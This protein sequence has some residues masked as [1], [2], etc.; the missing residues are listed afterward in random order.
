MVGSKDF[1]EQFV[2]GEM[3]VASFEAAGASVQNR[4]NLGGT[5]VNRQALEV[6]EIDVYAEYN[7]TGW[8]EHLGNVDPSDDPETLTQSVREQDLEENS[9]HWLSRSPFNNT[10][11]FATGPALTEEHGGEFDIQEMATYLQENPGA[12]VCMES[13]FPDR[14]DGLVLYQEATGHTIPQ[15]QINIIDTDLIYTE[16]AQGNCAFGE[17]FTTDGRIP[18]LGL[19]VVEDPVYLT[20]PPVRTSDWVLDPG[21]Q[22]SP[23]S[24][25][26]TVEIERPR[27]DVP[28]YLPGTNPYLSEYAVE[29]GLPLEAARGGADRP[30]AARGGAGR[31][32]LGVGIHAWAGG[33][34]APV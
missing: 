12:I 11:G 5:N 19:T 1:T 25:I 14:S 4:V 32:G 17:I 7:G 9:I 34:G 3:L 8:T 28:H 13:E 6:G 31:G 33:W 23:F 16:T 29:Q 26:P 21:V 2:L 24:C 10:Y 22:L 27:G 20:E 15:N 18:A 30:G